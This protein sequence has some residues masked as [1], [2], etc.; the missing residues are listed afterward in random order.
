MAHIMGKKTT[1][2]GLEDDVCCK[3]REVVLMSRRRMPG[4]VWVAHTRPGKRGSAAHAEVV[5]TRVEVE[6]SS[7]H[8][9]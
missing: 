1:V 2:R 6:S 7:T 3:V 8:S 4:G 9:V 5:E